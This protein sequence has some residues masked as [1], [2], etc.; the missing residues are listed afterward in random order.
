MQRLRKV[1]RREHGRM[2]KLGQR[3]PCSW[4]NTQGTVATN[5]RGELA[6]EVQGGALCVLDRH[7]AR[8]VQ[9][10]GDMRTSRS[11]G[12]IDVMRHGIRGCDAFVAPAARTLLRIGVVVVVG[13]RTAIRTRV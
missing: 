11:T 3:I 13:Q 6:I 9:V 1:Y 10:E 4:V 5:S 7:I 12:D 2:R 8:T